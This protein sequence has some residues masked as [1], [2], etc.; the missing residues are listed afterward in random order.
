[1]VSMRDPSPRLISAP[2]VLL[3][4]PALLIR[5]STRPCAAAARSRK[6]STSASS[7]TSTRTASASP[8]AART[9]SA[10]ASARA[11]S[12]SPSTT[13]AP[14]AASLSA[15]ARPIPPPPPVITATRSARSLTS[16]P[17]GAAPGRRRRPLKS[18]EPAR[19][20]AQDLAFPLGRQVIALGDV[21]ERVLARLHVRHVRRGHHLVLAQ[22]VEHDRQQLLVALAGEVHVPSLQVVA[23]RR[24]GQPRPLQAR[25]D[26]VV[27]VHAL[28]HVGQPVRAGL[29]EADPQAGVAGED[30]AAQEAEEGHH[31]R[32]REPDD[33][34]VKHV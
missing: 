26:A 13:L 18:V 33:L 22:P 6:A 16:P 24:L 1:M 9:A 11:R 30:A 34:R 32:Q 10:V 31:H 23:R 21:L 4:M 29:Q 25:V 3:K 15:S 27:L 17:V 20:R 12:R 2:G 28:D 14:T 5:T 8:P 19:V 7:A